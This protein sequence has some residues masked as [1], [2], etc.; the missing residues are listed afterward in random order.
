MDNTN[1]LSWWDRLKES[2]V[3]ESFG[4]AEVRR[5]LESAPGTVVYDD[6]ADYSAPNVYV[7]AKG[8]VTQAFESSQKYLLYLGGFILIAVVIYAAIPALIMRR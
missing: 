5:M 3:P 2:I 7:Q 8:A 1:T 4:E 6:T